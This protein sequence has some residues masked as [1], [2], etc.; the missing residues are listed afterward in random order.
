MG[1]LD[2]IRANIERLYGRYGQA[3]SSLDEQS[4]KVLYENFIEHPEFVRK[5]E[6]M[7]RAD[8]TSD[9]DPGRDLEFGDI[10]AVV[11]PI[12][13]PFMFSRGGRAAVR[14]FYNQA[15]AELVKNIAPGDVA[16]LGTMAVGKTALKLGA[17]HAVPPLIKAARALDLVGDVTAI[18]AGGAD[19][20]S[21]I[22]EGEPL[23]AAGGA[24]MGTL[25]VGGRIADVMPVRPELPPPTV[26]PPIGWHEGTPE[27]P[28]PEYLDQPPL[29]PKVPEGP[30]LNDARPGSSF[31]GG[32]TDNPRVKAAVAHLNASPLFKEYEGWTSEVLD[33]AKRTMLEL[34]ADVLDPTGA[35]KEFAG[36]VDQARMAGV[37]VDM[38]GSGT[39]GHAEPDWWR[40]KVGGE[41]YYPRLYLHPITFV[42]Q[43][44][45]DL[46]DYPR[47]QE[48]FDAALQAGGKEGLGKAIGEEM[49]RR[50]LWTITHELSHT[51]GFHHTIKDV[52]MNKIEGL[53]LSN[54]P[55]YGTKP[56]SHETQDYH[57]E[58]KTSPVAQEAFGKTGD[59][60]FE[61]V[62]RNTVHAYK[63][64]DYDALIAKA[65]PRAPEWLKLFRE[66]D[67]ISRGPA[68]AVPAPSAPLT[69]TSAVF[70][71][72]GGRRGGLRPG[73]LPRG[74]R[75]TGPPPPVAPGQ[76]PPP[77]D[78]PPGKIDYKKLPRHDYKVFVNL[79]AAATLHGRAARR[80]FKELLNQGQGWIESY[81]TK[82]PDSVPGGKEVAALMEELLKK[83]RE[84]G[85]PVRERANY[86]YHVWKQS[87]EEVR[88]TF[89]RLG[90]R[91]GFTQERVFGTYA[92]GI[93][94]GLTPKYTNPAD[95]IAE[96]VQRHK[97]LIADAGLYNHLRAE[98]LIKP[99]GK[100]P[101]GWVEVRNFP[102]QRFTVGGKEHVHP[103]YAHPKVAQTLN[104]YLDSPI[105]DPNPGFL[106]QVA[107]V[108]TEIKNVVMSSGLPWTAFNMHGINIARRIAGIQDKTRMSLWKAI[109]EPFKLINNQKKL[110]EDLN[111]EENLTGAAE[112]VEAGMT[113]NLEDHPFR[114]SESGD[115][116]PPV[117]K[118]F[119][120]A[121]KEARAAKQTPLG[122]H[123]GALRKAHEILFEDKL[124]QAYL[125]SR[126][127][128]F[129]KEQRTKLKEAGLEHK[130]ATRVAAHQANEV[131]GGI[132]WVEEGKDPNFQLFLRI[133]FNAPDWAKTNLR[134]GK[135]ALK[136]L[137]NPKDPRNKV[138][139]NIIRNTAVM[140]LM[141]NALNK[142][143]N[144]PG[145][146]TPIERQFQIGAGRAA[147]GRK[148]HIRLGGTAE[149]WVRLPYEVI[150]KLAN[151][152]LSGA[153]DVASARIHPMMQ[154]ITNIY[155][156]RNYWG[157]PLT[158]PGIPII[159]Q[160]ARIAHEATD[161]T[162][163]SYIKSPV[164]AIAGEA[165]PEETLA[166]SVE[167]PVAYARP[168]KGSRG[169]T[170]TT[171]T[172]S[173]RTRR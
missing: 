40:G 140:Y 54:H 33:L 52:G 3:L 115:V 31:F 44:K 168:D 67:E 98:K 122:K 49:L 34:P 127:Y 104:R 45:D 32:Q 21:G 161:V 39:R 159:T 172:R 145:E 89:R 93:K 119:W 66:A 170:R 13:G 147:S 153:A 149:D 22:Q 91:P 150:A 167:F 23:R 56:F 143:L 74:P 77:A 61:R 154:G 11:N 62:L 88:R 94:A 133:A 126:K 138:Y 110:V 99:F 42:N 162:M 75:P 92:E 82:G 27:Q 142:M 65:S 70:G 114:L 118:P 81:E 146:E 69:G 124:F 125:P 109:S 72:P 141:V 116:L 151:G 24:L 9:L 12:T 158:G 53:P 160:A 156:N 107:G 19:V 131:F 51:P 2:N 83:E 128:A 79:R 87:P 18:G 95:I 59:L 20:V 35:V 80:H 10:G 134:L 90:I 148:R 123:Y 103:W 136:W 29:R 73:G 100:Q 76:L 58:L 38:P 46:M 5:G 14:G 28:A 155:R 78:L 50:M 30:L 105:S 173:S 171:R 1:F 7:E 41:T 55:V 132:N 164:A 102:F 26:E 48:T 47:Y 60:A 37:D 16:T 130:E 43:L 120:E 85:V 163:P 57:P 112:F 84:Y 121:V 117:E 139:K 8:T 25:G 152:D 64:G 108:A 15:K 111:L 129:A 165:G 135:G 96:R 6:E 4:R 169:R 157:R 137:G 144:E 166:K 97:K 36:K 106:A 71:P 63:A 86:M 68:K 113:F 101:E 17:R